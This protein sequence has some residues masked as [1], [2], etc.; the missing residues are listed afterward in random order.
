MADTDD[1]KS[2]PFSHFNTN[3]LVQLTKEH[4]ESIGQT[5]IEN[6]ERW[7]RD[8]VQHVWTDQSMQGNHD[9]WTLEVSGHDCLL[10]EPGI[11]FTWTHEGYQDMYIVVDS[12]DHLTALVRE[13]SV[14][15]LSRTTTHT[16]SETHNNEKRNLLR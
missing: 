4:L 15:D 12:W 16:L 2:L 3:D 14:F 11:S 6:S 8:G 10:F 1:P 13:H 7:E 5:G 9:G